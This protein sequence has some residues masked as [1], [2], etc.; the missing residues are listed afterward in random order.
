MKADNSPKETNRPVPREKLES[1]IRQPICI[2]REHQ[3]KYW[4]RNRRFTDYSGHLSERQIN[5]GFFNKFF[6]FLS[7]ISQAIA[8]PNQFLIVLFISS[9]IGVATSPQISCNYE[10]FSKKI[11]LGACPTE[12]HHRHEIF[13]NTTTNTQSK[14]S[15][16]KT[17]DNKTETKAL[18]NKTKTDKEGNVRIT[19]VNGASFNIPAFQ[20]TLV[21]FSLMLGFVRWQI[22][23]Q[24]T[25]LTSVFERKKDINALFLDKEKKE[26]LQPLIVGATDPDDHIITREQK[27]VCIDQAINILDLCQSLSQLDNDKYID[28]A[29]K[30][31]AFMEID[32]LEFSFEKFTSGYL[33]SEQMHRAC[34]IFESRCL[35]SEFRYLATTQGLVYYNDAFHVVVAACI[36][37]GFLLSH[38]SSHIAKITSPPD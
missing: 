6:R 22:G 4:F 35:N 33:N 31:F 20:A 5:V 9:F 18:G 19:P 30:V 38:N 25:A 23:N 13:E 8:L 1:L 7:T 16:S 26:L 29:K 3:T 15:T 34:E 17:A 36:V 32:N 21:T 11:F 24:Q 2:N 14:A 28:A 12:E 27:E 37:R 10:I